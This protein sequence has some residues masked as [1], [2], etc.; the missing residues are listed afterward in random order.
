MYPDM[1]LRM[2]HRQVHRVVV[3]ENDT[4]NGCPCQSA[5]NVGPCHLGEING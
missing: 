1:G 3:A 4:P 2:H 5:A